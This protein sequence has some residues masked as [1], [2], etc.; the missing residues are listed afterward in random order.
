MMTYSSI[1]VKRKSLTA[2]QQ[3]QN[4]ASETKAAKWNS[5]IIYFTTHTCAVPTVACQNVLWC[6]HIVHE[7]NFRLALVV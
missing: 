1:P 3:A 7:V 6:G 5:A 4:K 2:S